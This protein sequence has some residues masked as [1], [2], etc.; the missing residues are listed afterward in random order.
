MKVSVF[1][2]GYVGAVTAACLSGRGHSVVGVDVQRLKVDEVNAGRSPIVEPGLEE[3]L[4]KGVSSG[5]LRAT[6]DCASAIAETELSIVCVGTPST[7]TGGLDLTYVR[8]VTG[9]IAQALENKDG[10][11]V[12]VF[13]ST[14]LPGSVRRIVR[15]LLASLVETGRVE[16]L[17][18]PE[19]LREG[20]AI[21]DFENPSLS[22]VGSIVG[23]EISP[24]ARELVGAETEVVTWEVSESIKYACN[25]FHAAKIVFANEMGRIGKALGVDSQKVMQAL[26]RDEVL[27]IS[28]AYLRPGAPY[29]GSC[30]PKDLRALTSLCREAGVAAPMFESLLVSNRDHQDALLKMV[31]ST[32]HKRVVLIGLS[33]K[34]KTDDLRESPMVELAQQLLGRGFELTIYDEQLNLSRL[35][36]A[37]KAEIDRRLPHLA[38]LLTT[39]IETTLKQAPSA[40]VVSQKGV[41]LPTLENCLTSEHA[42]IDVNGWAELQRLQSTYHGFLW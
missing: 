34:A 3:A 10:G 1:G 18:F 35:M 4:A 23:A 37:N 30:L 12:L 17:F 40:V 15:D 25:A 16:V 13:R 33:F 29:G 7:A 41:P 27:N 32:G 20:S 14:M 2:L 19:F 21:R 42:V 28:T 9:E 31:D 11:H 22:L 39:D 24:V 5:L 26:C 38:S 6:T 36:G 8:Q